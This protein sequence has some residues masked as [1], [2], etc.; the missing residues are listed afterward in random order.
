MPNFLDIM[1]SGK[2]LRNFFINTEAQAEYKCLI[3]PAESAGI[4]EKIPQ[5]LTRRRNSYL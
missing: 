5:E 4:Y 2:F 3:Q 1:P